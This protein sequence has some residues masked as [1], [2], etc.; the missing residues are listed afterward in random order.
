MKNT[1]NELI[2]QKGIVFILVILLS[3]GCILRKDTDESKNKN[4]HL[5][6]LAGQSNMAGRG[7]TDS[8]SKIENPN[9]LML[10]EDGRW[11]PAIDP[12]HFDKPV[13]GVGPGISFSQSMLA[14][15]KNK[16]IKI[17]LIPCAVGGTSINAW[18][19]GALDK[20]TKTYPYDDAIKRVRT[21]AK[22][23]TVKGIIWHQGESDN[24]K[25][26]SIGYIDKLYIV[27][28]N[29]REDIGE[30][31]PFVAGEIGHFKKVNLINTMIKN[32]PSKISNSEVVS[33]EGLWHIGD[34]TH[35]NAESA[36]ILGIRYAEAM[37]R[38]QK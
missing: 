17:G 20:F 21:A 31:I 19:K 28:S 13:A 23:G 37:Q 36:R 7:K 24:S 29:F 14:A 4:F 32:L 9:I 25:E 30:D 12:V 1:L 26:K 8:L 35:F 3:N 34:G 27:I 11:V 33:A 5:Y 22:Y 2:C 15:S 6:V 10:T 18:Q 16:R 38:L